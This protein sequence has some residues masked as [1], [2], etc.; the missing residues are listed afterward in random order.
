MAARGARFHV[1]ENIEQWFHK[2]DLVLFNEA[3]TRCPWS[4]GFAV[5][6]HEATKGGN[7]AHVAVIRVLTLVSFQ[8]NPWS[9]LYSTPSA[10]VVTHD[11]LLRGVPLVRDGRRARAIL[12]MYA[13]DLID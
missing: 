6:F 10:T 8:E 1:P 13:P 4:A 3:T 2:D 9:W 7:T 12:S 5:E 11:K